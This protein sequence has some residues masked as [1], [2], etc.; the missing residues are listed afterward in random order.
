MNYLLLD[1]N[2]IIRHLRKNIDYKTWIA[3]L[4]GRAPV[5]SPITLHELR[6]GVRPGSKWEETIDLYPA[7]LTDP[8]SVEDWIKAADLIRT[9]F[10]NE[11]KGAWIPEPK[12]FS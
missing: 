5:I 7:P 1:T 4:S 6:R 10:W 3:L 9:S 2:I 8:P 12:T 11:R